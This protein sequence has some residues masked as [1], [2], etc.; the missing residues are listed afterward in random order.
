DLCVPHVERDQP[1]VSSR[2]CVEIA[3]RCHLGD[4]ESGKLS[5]Q[6][7]DNATSRQDL[8]IDDHD[9]RQ[10][11]RSI[12]RIGCNSKIV[13]YVPASREMLKSPSLKFQVSSPQL[14]NCHWMQ[15]LRYAVDAGE[16]GVPSAT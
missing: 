13:H 1:N 14:P 7:I 11:L 3:C 12:E 2:K 16:V 9:H 6:D 15:M 10:S 8:I 5:L 4:F